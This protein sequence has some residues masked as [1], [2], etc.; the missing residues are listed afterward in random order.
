VLLGVVQLDATLKCSDFV[1]W[2]ERECR[3][4]FSYYPTLDPSKPGKE[5]SDCLGAGVTHGPRH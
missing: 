5:L 3:P 4:S 2:A 1:Q